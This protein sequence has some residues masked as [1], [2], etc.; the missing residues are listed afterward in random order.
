VN[1]RHLKQIVW[2]HEESLAQPKQ[3]GEL[4]QEPEKRTILVSISEIQVGKM[5]MK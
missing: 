1:S 3:T 4:R 5:K 2:Q